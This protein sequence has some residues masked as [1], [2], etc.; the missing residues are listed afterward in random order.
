M[1][2]EQLISGFEYVNSGLSRLSRHLKE[3]AWVSEREQ[4]REE[5]EKV[6]TK[7]EAVREGIPA[8]LDYSRTKFVPYSI[9]EVLYLFPNQSTCRPREGVSV[10]GEAASN[11][12]ALEH[13]KTFE[14]LRVRT[15]KNEASLCSRRDVP[16]PVQINQIHH[17][18]HSRVPTS[19]K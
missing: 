19:I 5:V 3:A 12:A 7:L 14:M 9:F 15:P 17:S 10:R 13:Q 16:W 8:S 11:V 6:S 4:L 18:F 1:W 2:F